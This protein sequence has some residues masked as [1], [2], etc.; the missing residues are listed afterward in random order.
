MSLT[1][2]RENYQRYIIF[3]Q[4]LRCVFFF[5]IMFFFCYLCSV[6]EIEQHVITKADIRN[7]GYAKKVD[8]LVM[9]FE[10][11]L[12]MHDEKKRMGMIKRVCFNPMFVVCNNIRT[13][14]LCPCNFIMIILSSVANTITKV[15]PR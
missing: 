14:F 10:T 7:L 4:F 2:G 3:C 12:L 1:D 13:C 8:N 9:L 5:D 15:S 11:F 6:V